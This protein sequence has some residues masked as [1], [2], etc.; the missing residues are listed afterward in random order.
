MKRSTLPLAA[1][2]VALLVRSTALTAAEPGLTFN[3]PKPQ[4]Y[5]L[6]ARASQIDSRAKEHP[7]ID[8][9]FERDG[10]PSDVERAVVDTRVAP[11]GKLVI[12]LM[13]YSGPLFERVSGY[14][15]HAIQVQDSARSGDWRG[16]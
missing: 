16:F 5:E 7:E 6:S 2:A 3:D 15:L 14:G 1:L 11:R 10:R 8:F 9:V 12:W 4:R 13:G